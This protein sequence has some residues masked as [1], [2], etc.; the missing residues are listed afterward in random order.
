MGLEV[1]FT[2]YLPTQ[3]QMIGQYMCGIFQAHGWIEAVDMTQ[4]EKGN[5]HILVK[6][7]ETEV[8]Q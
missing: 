3:F 2:P 1:D 5:Y 6:R 7:K 8:K 4:D